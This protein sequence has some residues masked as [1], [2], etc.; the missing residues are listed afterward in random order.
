LATCDSEV[1]IAEDNQK[2]VQSFYLPANEG[3]LAYRLL[4]LAIKGFSD[5]EI[6]W[7]TVVRESKFQ[8]SYSNFLAMLEDALELDFINHVIHMRPNPE[9]L[10]DFLK[11]KVE[12]KSV[13]RVGSNL[14]R[15][16]ESKDNEPK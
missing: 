13:I 11:S 3:V 12:E 14:S 4:D 5:E 8:W 6:N 1:D 9:H 7:L 15:R 16:G 10:P 2:L